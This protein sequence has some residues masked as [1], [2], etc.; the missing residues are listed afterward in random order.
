MS[1]YYKDQT[2]TDNEFS[3]FI[4][5]E[6]LTKY[7]PKSK[8]QIKQQFTPKQVARL[9]G[10]NDIAFF[11][12]YY[13]RDYFVPSDLNSNRNLAKVHYDIWQ[14]LNKMFIEDRYDKEEFILPRG[15][16]KSTVINKALTTHQHCYK[17]SRYT[18]VLGNKEDDSIQFIDDTKKMLQNPRIKEE[19]GVLVNKK[20]RTVNKQELELTNDTKIQAFSWGSSVRGTTYGCI[21]G[22]FRP[23]LIIADDVLKE[24]DILTDEAKEKTINKYYKE[25]LEVGDKPVF[26]NGKKIKQAS[27]FLVIGTPLAQG[28]FILTIRDDPAFKVFHKQ[29]CAFDVD[30][31]F[32]NHG[33][34]RKFRELLFNTKDKD[35]QETA[36]NYYYEN[37]SKMDFDTIWEKYNCLDLATTYFTKRLAFMQELQCD[38]DQVGDIWIER[39][40]AIPRSEVE[41]RTFDKTILSVDQA[42]ANTVKSDFY[43][44]TV[45]GKSGELYFVRR[46]ELHKYDSRTEFELYISKVINLLKA[47]PEITHVVLEKNT[48][49]GVDANRI[50]E[51]IEEDAELKTRDIEVIL[52]YNTKN[53]NDR[54]ATI[55]DKINS[56]M[57]VFSKED[58]QYNEQVKSFKGQAYSKND[59]AIDS[60]EMAVN[61][62]DQIEVIHPIQIFDRSLLGL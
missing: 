61:N 56:G 28:D 24:D 2:L 53:K 43:G 36:H 27:K 59:D 25:V 3:V 49:K 57:I 19:F 52:V 45:L 44:F 31:Y 32:K 8:D 60:L 26:R 15:S 29:V 12:L 22:I 11:C 58:N 41:S 33:Y 9:L 6:Y 30:S 13:L 48:Y 7:F 34:W 42:S 37:R 50:E 38:C 39:V 23:T 21:D 1:V 4:I 62:I 40:A 55:T 20:E 46:G 51:R 35:R 14:E 54:I 18:I 5:D 47:Y 17:K 10:E 16:A